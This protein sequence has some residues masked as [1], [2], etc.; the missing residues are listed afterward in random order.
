VVEE[1]CGCSILIV[2]GDLESGEIEETPSIT[3]AVIEAGGEVFDNPNSPP[4]LLKPGLSHKSSSQ[5][6]KPRSWP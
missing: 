3:V 4:F 1:G 6:P 2:T 5:V